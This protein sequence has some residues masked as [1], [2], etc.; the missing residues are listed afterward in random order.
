M[1]FQPKCMRELVCWHATILY[2]NDIILFK[3]YYTLNINIILHLYTW[4]TKL[5]DST[6]RDYVKNYTYN[7][8]QFCDGKLRSPCIQITLCLYTYL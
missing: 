5:L 1:F 4:S 8:R 3:F 7:R 2:Y 6:G